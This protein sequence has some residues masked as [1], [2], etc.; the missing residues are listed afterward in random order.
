MCGERGACMAKGG[1]HG[2]GHACQ[3]VC[4]VREHAWQGGMYGR[5]VCMAG[6]ACGR[7]VCVAEGFVWQR[8]H[9]WHGGACKVAGAC[10]G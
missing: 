10:V 2:G 9:A 7:G 4:V 5:G 1:M 3:G 8:E 6:G